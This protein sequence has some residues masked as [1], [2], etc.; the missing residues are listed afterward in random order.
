MNENDYTKI[1][2]DTTVQFAKVVL[3]ANPDIVFNYVSG[4]ST[5]SNEQGKIMWARVK[6]KTEN[7]LNKMGFKGQYNFRPG[8]MAPF[9]SQKN[10]KPIFKVFGLFF[11][12]LFPK[13]SLTLKEVGQ[14]MI[15]VSVKGY[16]QNVL[17]VHDIKVLAN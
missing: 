11:P 1:T 17:E 10:V 13:S 3:E 8:F 14:A 9:K 4:R 6:G 16:H 12:K 2:F 5:T 7:T 15:N